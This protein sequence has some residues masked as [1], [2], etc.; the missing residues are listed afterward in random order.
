MN[1]HRIEWRVKQ[2]RNGRNVTPENTELVCSHNY[3]DDEWQKWSEEGRSL[4]CIQYMRFNWRLCK[5]L[6]KRTEIQKY[7]C[8]TFFDCY[9]PAHYSLCRHTN[10]T[11]QS[12][13]A[14]E[15][16]RMT[17]WRSKI[18]FLEIT[19]C[20]CR[21]VSAP[22]SVGGLPSCRCVS[23]VVTTAQGSWMLPELTRGHVNSLYLLHSLYFYFICLLSVLLTITRCRVSEQT[24]KK[25]WN[26]DTPFSVSKWASWWVFWLQSNLT[27]SLNM[28]Q[29]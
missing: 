7:N 13:P 28:E 29:L 15:T 3:S 14:G 9:L 25:K 1:E 2:S 27:R 17:T 24:G 22:Y 18:T 20:T 12:P 4:Y 11:K 23:C 6:N 19:P 10:C 8:D 16:P 5:N 21:C 26:D